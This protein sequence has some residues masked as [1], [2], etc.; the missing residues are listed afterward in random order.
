MVEILEYQEMLYTFQPYI[1]FWIS[2]K[3]PY[4]F[5]HNEKNYLNVSGVQDVNQSQDAYDN[6]KIVDLSGNG[7]Q[8][9]T[10]NGTIRS[11]NDA[12][13]FNNST[14]TNLMSA[15]YFTNDFTAFVIR[16]RDPTSLSS[17]N[18]KWFTFY[19][20][21]SGYPLYKG[22]SFLF[23]YKT[24]KYSCQIMEKEIYGV[25]SNV[26]NCDSKKELLIF[27]MNGATKSMWSNNMI[28]IFNNLKNTNNETI[29]GYVTIGSP[30][31]Y[32]SEGGSFFVSEVICFN[33]S[34]SYVDIETVKN[35]LL[36]Y[37]SVD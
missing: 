7:F 35:F 21:V 13:H 26:T 34:L 14:L 8:G 27:R 33:T 4:G 25:N 12:I 20:T 15:Y 2:A 18:G 23:D 3:H 19:N 31:Y 32:T 6:N 22:D 36:K 37:Y 29:S 9:G 11:F 1:K 10:Y 17:N 5:N 24:T 30:H 16:Q 28:P